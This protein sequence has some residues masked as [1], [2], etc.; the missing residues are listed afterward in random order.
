MTNSE[1]A[2]MDTTPHL[3]SWSS[4]VSENT[5]SVSIGVQ[6]VATTH[7]TE[8]QGVFLYV[9][10]LNTSER[11]L[12]LWGEDCSRGNDNLSLEILALDDVLLPQPVIV[13]RGPTHWL[14]NRFYHV[15]LE[16]KDLAVRAV[17][18]HQYQPGE[19]SNLDIIRTDHV[20]YR[21]FPSL[22]THT[23]PHSVRMQA[24]FRSS[25]DEYAPVDGLWKGEAVSEVRDYIVWGPY[26]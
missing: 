8:R 14:K 22:G 26:L 24:V 10:L 23:Y 7:S 4:H 25:D 18:L 6:E 13:K 2:K 20:N 5:L 17:R 11:P 21:G 15:T 3:D 12:K 9:I 19:R 16:P 1:D